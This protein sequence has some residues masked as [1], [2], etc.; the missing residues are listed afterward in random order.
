METKMAGIL[1]ISRDRKHMK[2]CTNRL[3]HLALG[4]VL[5]LG[6]CAVDP[7]P[8]PPSME[9]EMIS[10]ASDGAGI[11]TIGGDRGAT[12]PGASLSFFN[13]NLDAASFGMFSTSSASD[14]SFEISMPGYRINSYRV[15][16]S[17]PDELPVTLDFHGNYDGSISP[18]YLPLE[19]CLDISSLLLD[20][21]D[22]EAGTQ[23]F[24]A[25]D[26]ENGCTDLV[27]IAITDIYLSDVENFIIF[28]STLGDH[29]IEIPQGQTEQIGLYM[30]PMTG[31]GEIV[32]TLVVG[33][34]DGVRT[35]EA[36][37]VL[38]GNAV[39]P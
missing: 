1:R 38:R 33:Y 14:G 32:R 39:A 29:G 24:M 2:R 35:F 36:K 8:Q 20:F 37:V 7:L 26:I 34:T 13:F 9:Y 15:V 31:S 5:T 11:V 30:S 28:H 3:S 19:E 12:I 23:E 17:A 16:L 18:T 6:G 10:I 22:V 4:M 27:A 25:V 21:G